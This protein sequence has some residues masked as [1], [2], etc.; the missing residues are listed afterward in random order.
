MPTA[1]EVRITSMRL[2]WKFNE[3]LINKNNTVTCNVL[4]QTIQVFNMLSRDNNFQPK[5]L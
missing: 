5:G 2:K 1:T 4:I 3:I